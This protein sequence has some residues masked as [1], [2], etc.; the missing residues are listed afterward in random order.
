MKSQTKITMTEAEQKRTDYITS[1][2]KYKDQGYTVYVPIEYMRK[3]ELSLQ[4]GGN[5]VFITDHVRK[6]DIG[7]DNIKSTDAYVSGALIKQKKDHAKGL[8]IN[9]FISEAYIATTGKI[10][11]GGPNNLK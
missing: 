8:N 2:S 4:E 11:F 5:I 1:L 3:N 6:V 7:Y 10:I 9:K